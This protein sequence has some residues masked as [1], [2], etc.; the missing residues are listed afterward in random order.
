MSPTKITQ[1][2]PGQ[3]ALIPSILEKWTRVLCSTDPRDRMKGNAPRSD[4]QQA[5]TAVKAAYAAMGKQEPAIRF[6]SSPHAARLAVFEQQPPRQTAQQLGAPLLM[7]FSSQLQEQLQPQLDEELWHQLRIQVSNQQLQNL[8]QLRAVLMWQSQ[9]Q[10]SEQQLELLGQFR[11]QWLRQQ[12]EQQQ[13]ELRKQLIL[14]PG[15]QLL[16]QMGDSLWQ[17]IG[18]PLWQHLANQPLVEWGQQQLQQNPFLQMMDVAG[19]AFYGLLLPG[20]EASSIALIDFCISVLNCEYDAKQWEAY[21]SLLSKC[22]CVFPFEKTCIICDRP[23]KLSFDNEH[24]L[25]AEGEPAIQFADGYRLYYYRG[26]SLPEKYWVH[27][28]HWQA[29]WLLEEHN[30]ELRRVLI[31]GIGYSRI[32]QELQATELDS[33]REYTLLRIESEVDVE[34]IYLLKMSCPS[35]GYI[36]AMRVPPTMR[37][38][39]EAISWMN[40]GTDPEEFS[41]E[42]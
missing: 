21:Q 18:E 12:W 40:W 36:H 27:P 41:V 42:T 6:F 19:F 14:A 38:A 29:R 35:T 32:C 33:W 10:F 20:L 16:M 1:L 24:R 22:G 28:H 26:V 31:Q 13:E 25:H 11:E 4:R 3:E 15:G 5:E 17:N 30:A 7:P 39:R 34:P 2:T 23:T 8:F 37:S 9:E